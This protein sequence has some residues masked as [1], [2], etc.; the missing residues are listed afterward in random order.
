MKIVDSLKTQVDQLGKTTNASFA[1]KEL[2]DATTSLNSAAT[3]A[4]NK[5]LQQTTDNAAAASKSVEDAKSKIASADQASKRLADVKAAAET[6]FNRL[7]DEDEFE[8]EAQVTKIK[9]QLAQGDQF[10]AKQDLPNVLSTAGNAERDINSLRSAFD[11]HLA[12][13]K[14]AEEEA[15]RVA[16]AAEAEEEAAR[17]AAAAAEEEAAAKRIAAA[18]TGDTSEQTRQAGDGETYVVRYTPPNHDSLWRIA[19]RFY[20]DAS[21]WPLIFMENKDQ[22]KNPDLIF[23]GQQFTI[24]ALD[25]DMSANREAVRKIRNENLRNR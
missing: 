25:Q 6:L 9:D 1:Q 21:F 14:R 19:W 4:G 11:S 2:A 18:V 16:R 13:Q 24:P 12:A 5:N 20:K 17:R 10:F 7:P 8:S 3:A 23:P 15:A 22:I